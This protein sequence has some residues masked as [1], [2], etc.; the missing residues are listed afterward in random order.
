M[1]ALKLLLL[2][3]TVSTTNNACKYAPYISLT[4]TKQGATALTALPPLNPSLHNHPYIS[5]YK[6]VLQEIV[7]ISNA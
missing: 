3:L 1:V 2:I 7:C 4:L 5:S 6:L